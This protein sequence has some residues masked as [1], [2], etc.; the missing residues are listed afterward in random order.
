VGDGIDT[1]TLHA[2]R[3]HDWF[4]NDHR[5]SSND[6]RACLMNAQHAASLLHSSIPGRPLRFACQTTRSA[7]MGAADHTSGWDQVSSLVCRSPVVCDRLLHRLAAGRRRMMGRD[8]AVVPSNSAYKLNWRM[9]T[10]VPSTSE[11]GFSHLLT[12]HAGHSFHLTSLRAGET[13]TGSRLCPESESIAMKRASLLL[14]CM[15]AVS[16]FAASRAASQAAASLD[17]RRSCDQ[18]A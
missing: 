3:S 12:S 7:E 6:D 11:A 16:T 18:P 8:D 4:L 1:V 17:L 13:L 14:A 5:S 2:P 9:V 10:A 15:F